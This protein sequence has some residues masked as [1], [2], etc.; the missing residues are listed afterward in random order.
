MRRNFITIILFF[1]C[2]I[3][4]TVFARQYE[5]T[6]PLITRNQNPVYL[7]TLSLMPRRAES[8]PE[9]VLETRVDSAY[10]SIF[11]QGRN[12]RADLNLD[13]EFWRLAVLADYGLDNGLQVGVEV[14]FV[15]FSGGFLDGFIQAFHGV[16][17]FPNAGRDA[18]VD[19]DFHYR[20]EADGA[21]RL[22]F[23]PAT[24]GLGDIALRVKGQI[25]GENDD[26]PAIAW[27][28]DLKFPTGR[29]SRGFGNGALDFGLGVALDLSWR[30]LHGYFNVGYYVTGGNDYL[31]GYMHNEML[32]Y[33]LAGELVI[34]DS[35]SLIVQIQGGTPLLTGTGIDA[36]DGVPLDLIVGFKGEERKLFGQWGDLIWQVGFAEDVSCQGPSIDFTAYMSLGVRFD[37]FERKRPVG[38]W[39]AENK[40]Q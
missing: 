31:D 2:L 7:Q 14:P 20:F 17:G 40:F 9:G 32:A 27:F 8:L 10:S 39:I 33:M 28:A 36:W 11:E 12:A 4:S 18:A 16:F 21:T 38:D 30:R 25:T 24:W 29:R 15:H 13:M 34:I 6:G 22:N 1:S 5:G 26:W 23:P 35:L 37:L 3:P 19:N